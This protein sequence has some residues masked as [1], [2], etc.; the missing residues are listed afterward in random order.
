MKSY[1]SRPLIV[2]DIFDERTRDTI[3][4]FVNEVAP[5]IPFADDK[6]RPDLGQKFNRRWCNDLP[7]FTD[8][9]N[10][11]TPYAS[12]LFGEEVKPSY[13]FL[14]RYRSGG[15]CPLH[16]DRPQCRYTI[17][18]LIQQEE[19]EPWPICIGP[20]MSD[21]EVL[22]IRDHFPL[23]EARESIIEQTDWTTCLLNPN[24][25][26]C[27]SGTHAWH[28]RPISTPT[29]VDLVFFHFVGKAF[30]GSLE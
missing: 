19:S 4:R 11:L 3:L 9:H 5:M 13:N 26:V 14:S 1:V 21:D 2:R 27:Y 24:D 17:D 7:F 28:Y 16:V 22:E 20:Q 18:Y 23:G 8:I 15:S 25:A 30:R 6:G 10:Q 29:P 12:E